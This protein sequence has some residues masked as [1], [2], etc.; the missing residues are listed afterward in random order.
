MAVYTDPYGYILYVTEQVATNNYL[1]VVRNNHS[2][3]V[4]GTSYA[5]VAFADGTVQNV[6][7]SAANFEN[8]NVAAGEMPSISPIRMVLPLWLPATHMLP[9]APW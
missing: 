1:Y 8:L 6:Y 4:D 7:L 3:V 2:S 5:T 9:P